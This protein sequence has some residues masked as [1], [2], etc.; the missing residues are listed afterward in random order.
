MNSRE[1]STMEEGN[2]Y[3]LENK[4]STVPDFDPRKPRELD[5]VAGYMNKDSDLWVFR[6]FG[7]LHLFNILYLQQRLAELEN[8]LERQIEDGKDEGFDKLY[9]S[10]QNAL[11][12]YGAI[13]SP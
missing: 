10:I 3:R 11:K 1:I 12:E 9:P 2:I 5:L 13:L 8:E 7:K 6:R 4:T